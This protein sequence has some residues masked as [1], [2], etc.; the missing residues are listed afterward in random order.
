VK[1]KKLKNI[2]KL[3]EGFFNLYNM[4]ISGMPNVS[5]I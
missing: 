1:F 5:L 3:V 4:L 2:F